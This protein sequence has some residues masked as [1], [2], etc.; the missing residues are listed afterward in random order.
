MRIEIAGPYYDDETGET[1]DADLCRIVMTR[2][3]LCKSSPT[4][5]V[6]IGH[7][8]PSDKSVLIFRHAGLSA[9]ETEAATEWVKELLTDDYERWPD[10]RADIGG[11]RQ[12]C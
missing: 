1:V 8:R 10:N 11:R 7:C 2:H 5:R 12:T 6:L 3:R 9:R 4:G